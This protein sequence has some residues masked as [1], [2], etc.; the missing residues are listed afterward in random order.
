[1]WKLL[2]GSPVIANM[3]AA[4]YGSLRKPLEGHRVSDLAREQMLTNWREAQ[5]EGG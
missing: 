5:A 4:G 1:M 2:T 3:E